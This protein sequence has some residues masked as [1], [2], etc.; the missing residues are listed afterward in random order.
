MKYFFTVF[1]CVL[2]LTTVTSKSFIKTNYSNISLI[3]QN[4][5]ARLAKFLYENGDFNKAE[6]IYKQVLN[7]EAPQLIKEQADFMLIEI[8]FQKQKYLKAQEGYIN[9]IK[10]RPFGEFTH[11]AYKRVKEINKK[12]M[13]RN[14][15]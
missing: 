2:A 12:I 6:I 15:F 9:Y 13:R 14:S 3:F 10:N 5:M 11:Q 8:E 4:R 1:I 7:Y